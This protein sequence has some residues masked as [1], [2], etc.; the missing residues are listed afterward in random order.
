MRKGI[1]AS[2][3][4]AIGRSHVLIKKEDSGRQERNYGSGSRKACFYQALAETKAHVDALIKAA[5]E[6]G[7][8]SRPR[9]S[10]PIAYSWKTRI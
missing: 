3:G 4:I 8:E 2:P 7:E 1:P 10:P 5:Q 6:S 9:S